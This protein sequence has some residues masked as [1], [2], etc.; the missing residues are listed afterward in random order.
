MATT[1]S[2]RS[3]Y[4]CFFRISEELVTCRLCEK[5]LKKSKDGCTGN[6]RFHLKTDHKAEFSKFVEQQTVQKEKQEAK[7]RAD[8][9][10][11]L[12][13]PFKRTVDTST[14][15]IPDKKVKTELKRAEYISITSDGWSSAENTH[16]LLSLTVHFVDKVTFEPKYFIVGVIPL[17]GPHSAENMADRLRNCMST[18]S[19]ERAKV[20]VMIR[21]GATSMIK[22]SSI[23]GIDSGHCFAHLLQLAVKDGLVTFPSAKSLVETMKTIVRKMRKSGRDK[24]EFKQCLIDCNLAERL[25]LPQRLST[26]PEE[27]DSLSIS[28]R[29]I[30]DGITRRLNTMKSST[31]YRK[32]E[33]ATL[34][35]PRFKSAFFE[36]PE[37]KHDA[38]L[39]EVES[40]AV[41]L[42]KK[43]GSDQNET[44]VETDQ[45]GVEDSPI[46]DPFS[47]FLSQE[48]VKLTS[49][50]SPTIADAK[51]KAK[52]ELDEYFSTP[53]NPQSDPY[54][55]WASPASEIKF[56]L[57]RSLACCHFSAPATSAESERLFSA[58]G[59]TISDLR[60]NLLDE[61]PA[62]LLFL[63][64]NMRLLGFD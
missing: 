55:F 50:P 41:S 22:M 31:F 39:L 2:A 35:D 37:M 56:P 18:F 8:N 33:L 44:E 21:D 27:N 61:T 34:L 11:Q 6:M 64:S 28:K 52:Q 7:A 19:L 57:L 25:L 62:K 53:P 9:S 26:E 4:D 24:D 47:H 60:T 36:V 1:S 49:S 29:T 5:T 58:A 20:F 15:G 48:P 46:T 16:S 59:L 32:M 51:L 54:E 42:C 63:H 3:K 14:A 17:R 45:I 43:A 23:L 10:R 12:K 13:L 40:L 30:L 38:L